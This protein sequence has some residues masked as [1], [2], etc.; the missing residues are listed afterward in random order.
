MLYSIFYILDLNRAKETPMKTY[1]LIFYHDI[2]G[3]HIIENMTSL[4]AKK[5]KKEDK[6]EAVFDILKE[7]LNFADAYNL[8]GDLWQKYLIY[9]LIQCENIY[10]TSCEM[11]GSLN[12]T[13]NSA[14][15]SDFS[16][17]YS[18]FNYNLNELDEF[19]RTDIFSMIENFEGDYRQDKIY[20]KEVADNIDTLYPEFVSAKNAD[21][22]K[23]I[24]TKFYAKN[25]SGK[26]GLN[27]AFRI[28]D[29]TSSTALVTPISNFDPITFDDLIGYEEQKQRLIENTSAFIEGKNANNCLLF[30]DAG[31][32]KSSSVRAVLNMF[33][34]DGLRIIEIYKHQLH[35][36]ND[37]IQQ[38]KNRN[39][40]FILFMD[41][42]SFE[43]FET[44]Y[45][46]LK[47]VIEGGLER[48]PDNV[49]IYATSNRRH[50][51]KETFADRNEDSDDVH[52]SD[53]TQEKLSLSARFGV[54]ILFVRPLP[55]EYQN[56]VIE[57]ARMNGITIP[58]E[59]LI[60]KAIR[61]DLNH[62]GART[63]RTAQQFIDYLLGQI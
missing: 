25:G 4:I 2:N 17:I 48:K 41:D 7:L 8:S 32:G 6:P 22:F 61:W 20:N 38:I 55:T 59:E 44:E 53:T 58:D 43:D 31:T 29:D 35:K 42:L 14:L 11:R 60:K 63:G 36:L 39:Y 45:K 52:I 57:L 18:M 9:V 34:D 54:T 51:I 15:K 24:V 5:M 62:G 30:G 40:K 28:Q 47:A 3:Y 16:L 56:M 19:L 50:L 23:D 49:L 10:T 46:Y 21:E 1:E 26:F 13:I 37:V 33:Y 12:S 27:R